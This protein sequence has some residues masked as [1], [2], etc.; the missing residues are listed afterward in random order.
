M[1]RYVDSPPLDPE[2][3]DAFRFAPR[4]KLLG[5]FSEAGVVARSERLLQFRIEAPVSVEEFWNLRRE[6]SEKLSEKFATLSDNQKPKVRLGDAFFSCRVFRGQRDEFPI[7][8]SYRERSQ[9]QSRV[10]P[11][12]HTAHYRSFNGTHC[13]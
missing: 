8:G 3:P 9:S 7:R 10:M 13:D 11:N 4:G 12:P 6:M 1:D 5:V 2:A